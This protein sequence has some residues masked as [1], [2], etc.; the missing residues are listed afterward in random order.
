MVTTAILSEM[1]R[2]SAAGL[3]AHLRGVAALL[4]ERGECAPPLHAQ[5]ALGAPFW[6]HQPRQFWYALFANWVR[7]IIEYKR[8]VERH[9]QLES[10]YAT[11]GLIEQRFQ[12]NFNAGKFQSQM[13]PLPTRRINI[14]ATR[15]KSDFDFIVV[16]IASFMMTSTHSHDLSIL[17][18]DA[19]Y[20]WS[21]R[22]SDLRF[23]L[24]PDCSFQ[25]EAFA[26]L[27]ETT[28]SLPQSKPRW[29][30]KPAGRLK[31]VAYGLV[32]Q[33]DYAS[34]YFSKQ[35][36]KLGGEARIN[37]IDLLIEPISL[38]E[39]RNINLVARCRDSLERVAK[40]TG[41]RMRIASIIMQLQTGGNRAY[42]ITLE[43]WE[44][45][46]HVEGVLFKELSPLSF[47]WSD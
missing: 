34:D 28:A 36:I 43:T 3:A 45:G 21:C 14:H 7:F 25:L 17:A 16:N 18:R 27:I 1:E 42:S 24:T 15:H 6:E 22:R 47:K 10:Y 13:S 23:K 20:Y 31:S 41:D 29:G 35:I 46:E 30:K 9:A 37:L 4:R 32:M 8:T 2:K 40:N 38:M 5:Q 12:G 11:L 33:L 26:G 44:R 39:F 19:F